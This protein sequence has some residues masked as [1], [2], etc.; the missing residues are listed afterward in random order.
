MKPLKSLFQ[1]IPPAPLLLAISCVLSLYLHSVSE[2]PIGT[3]AA[4]LIAV[5]VFVLVLSASFSFMA[6]KQKQSLYI[7]FFVLLFFSYGEAV[8]LLQS[9]KA[10]WSWDYLV[11]PLWIALFAIIFILIKKSRLNFSS[12]NRFFL[13]MSIFAAFMPA[14]LIG[15]YEITDR[16]SYP[17]AESPLVLPAAKPTVLKQNLPD[18]YYIIPDSYT[19]SAALNKYMGYDQSAFVQ[20]LEAKGFFVP[21]RATSN[22]PKTF[23]SLAST[24]NMEY[25]DYLSSHKGSSDETIVAPLINDNNVKKFLAPLGYKYY[26][27]GAWW[28]T[29]HNPSADGNFTYQGTLGSLNL[30]DYSILR[31]TLL[32]PLLAPLIAGNSDADVANQNRYQFEMLPE[33]AK[34]PGP[35][36]VLAHILTP[37][38]PYIYGRD[39]EILTRAETGSKSDDVNYANQAACAGRKL[40]D[41]VD[42][43]IANSAKPPVILIQSDEGVPYVRYWLPT[44]DQWSAASAAE[45]Q[46]KF[47]IFSA[48]YLPGAATSTLYDSISNVNSFREILDLYFGAALPLLP[49]KN[50]IFS[51]MENLYQFKEVTDAVNAK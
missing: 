9:W 13:L 24:L 51:D 18:I 34:Q 41:V 45:L 37:H 6:D 23:L 38:L 19:S 50:Y 21:K 32:Y 31:S 16:L 36:F 26:Q 14:V 12:F 30:L 25:V 40:E 11:F 47:P 39:C 49:D 3:L 7:C 29:P 1:N 42:K 44:E 28:V 35:K 4:P 48:Y 33:I 46:E 2:M 43:I 10:G 15:W 22:Y 17:R 8:Y 20:G 27:L 5:A